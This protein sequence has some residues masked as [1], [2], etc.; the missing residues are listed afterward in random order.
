VISIHLRNAATGKSIQDEVPFLQVPQRGEHIAIKGMLWT[1]TAVIHYW[2][3]TGE[4][5]IAVDITP[6][7]PPKLGSR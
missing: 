4:P 2:E 6:P 5:E 7:P 3:G 1:V